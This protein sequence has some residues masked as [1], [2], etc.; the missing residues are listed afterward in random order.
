[1]ELR[2]LGAVDLAGSTGV[3]PSGA[4]TQPKRLAL[5]AYLAAAHPPGFHSRDRLLYLFWPDLDACRARGA[6]NQALRYLRKCLGEDVLLSRGTEE[7]G[8]DGDRI[9]CDVPAFRRAVSEDRLEEAIELYRGEFLEGLYLSDSFGFERWVEE[10]RAR[11]RGEAMRASW[12]LAQRSEASGEPVQAAH[13]ARRAM[14]FEPMDEGSVQRA[15]ELLDRVGDRAGAVDAFKAFAHRLRAEYELDPSPETMLLAE[16]IR[17]REVPV[18]RPKVPTARVTGPPRTTDR[19]TPTLRPRVPRALG[20]VSAREG[21][22]LAP[23]PPRDRPAEETEIEKKEAGWRQ[24]RLREVVPVAL[25]A[26]VAL[27]LLALWVFRGPGTPPGP[28]SVAV[29][30][31]ENL[32]QLPGDAYFVDGI[33]DQIITQLASIGSLRVTSR[34]SVQ[35]FRDSEASA[36]RIGEALDVAFLLEGTVLRAGEAVRLN[37]Q[38]IDTG[39][40]N[41]VWTGSWEAAVTADNLLQVQNEIA[42]TVASELRV[43]LTPEEEIRLTVGATRNDDAYDLFLRGLV[44]DQFDAAATETAIL[45]HREALELDPGFAA[46]HA[47]L[48]FRYHLRVQNFGFSPAYA[49]T[50][51]AL[52]REAVR[53]G[54]NLSFGYHALGSNLRLL[55]RYG[56]AEEALL[57]ALRLS[58][59]SSESMNALGVLLRDQGRYDEALEQFH[60]AR[61]FDPLYPM[62][63]ANVGVT[64]LLLDDVPGC[65][66]W[67][68]QAFVMRADLPLAHLVAVYA[69]IREGAWESARDRSRGLMERDP[70]GVL[71]QLALGEV[72]WF[73]GKPEEAAASFE[74]L[75]RSVPDW[76]NPGTGRS[77][78]L[79]YALALARDG[80]VQRAHT[81]L[82]N[83]ERHAARRLEGGDRNPSL[84]LELAAIHAARGEPERARMR[85]DQAV[86][87]GWRIGPL[88]RLDP[89]FSS[90]REEPWFVSL[91][92]RIEADVAAMRERLDL[93]SASEDPISRA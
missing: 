58:P 51:V 7:V 15:I 39:R 25:V 44:L 47:R 76:R 24:W 8:L 69:D 89:A 4:L 2:L 65:R 83:V 9:W 19:G 70:R 16:R 31:F 22:P 63:P 45:L 18:A 14:G 80:E 38:L 17:R 90:V 77:V 59:S 6:L 48:A 57:E 41:H 91:L 56:E 37:L 3:D 53:L 54:P 72:A 71:G 36:R 93:A 23:E 20:V 13:W 40:D 67:L 79:S 46:A 73:Q 66:Q 81:V 88:I 64:H 84:A 1:M 49:D 60:R 55:G 52:A 11:L 42:R 43:E 34:R 50:G 87:L 68:D 82:A 61:P 75:Y 28:R 30:P 78:A 74:P 10:E 62:L 85:L 35:Q 86:D 12:T 32:S 33:H 92:G 29:I 5:L 27:V 21:E 26:P